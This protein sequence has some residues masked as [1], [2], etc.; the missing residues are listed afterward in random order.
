M[1]K[2]TYAIVIL[3]SAF[4]FSCSDSDKDVIDNENQ[5]YKVRY[6]GSCKTPNTKIRVLY[7]IKNA[8]LESAEKDVIEEFHT[9]PFSKELTMQKGDYCYLS[10]SADYR[11][12]EEFDAN[13]EYT[14]KIFVDEKEKVSTSNK[15][16]AISNFLLYNFE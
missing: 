6:E 13:L 7:T 12:E 10:V 1:S 2:L 16:V 14:S 11:N 15:T 5:T 3:L 9:K 4:L 8:K